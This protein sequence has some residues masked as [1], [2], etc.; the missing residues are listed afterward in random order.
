LAT[1]LGQSILRCGDPKQARTELGWVGE[2]LPRLPQ[3]TLRNDEN[4]QFF[5]DFQENRI[6]EKLLIFM[7]SEGFLKNLGRISST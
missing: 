2:N 4:P 1:S 3:T 7:I 5:I 6:N